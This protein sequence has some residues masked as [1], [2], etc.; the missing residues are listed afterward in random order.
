MKI[1]TPEF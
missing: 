1:E